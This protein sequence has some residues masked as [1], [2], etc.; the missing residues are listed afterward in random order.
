MSVK[1]GNTAFS[2]AY[3]GSNHVDKIAMGSSVIYY[4]LVTSNLKIHIDAENTD[5]YPGSGNTITDLQGTANATLTNGVF[6]STSPK[7][8]EIDEDHGVHTSFITFGNVETFNAPQDFTFSIWLEFT[9][10]PA[11]NNDAG[12]FS[13]GPHNQNAPILCWYDATVGNPANVGSGN[14]KTISFMVTDEDGVDHWIAAPS[15]SIE[16]GQVYNIVVQKRGSDSSHADHG[17]SRI[18]INNVKKA[19][20]TQSSTDGIKNTTDPLKIGAATQNTGTQDSDMKIYAFHAYD[21]FL[22]DAQIDQNWNH[23]KDRFGL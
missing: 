10:L 21:S 12:I 14:T 9:N 5:S 11:G 15:D 17:Q 3:V 22:T 19:D 16:E 6:N 20:H 8:W 7:N 2:K 4:G 23:L 13:K 18:W 1:L